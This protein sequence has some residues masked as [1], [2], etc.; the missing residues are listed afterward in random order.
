M[1][2]QGRSAPQGVHAV[3]INLDR[4]QPRLAAVSTEFA[5]CGM[6]F[7]RFAGVNGLAVPE[8]ARPYFFGADGRP[9]QTLTRGEVGCYA[10]HLIL[11]RRVAQGRCEAPT[12]ICEDDIGLPGDFVDILH[13]ALA[14]ADEGWDIIRLSA[15]S[16]RVMWRVCPMPEGYD[17]VRYSKVPVLLGA[18]LISQQGARK[19]LKPGLRTRPVDIDLARPWELDLNIYG[20]APAPVYQ[21]TTNSSSIDALEKRRYPR[22][23]HGFL[24]IRSRLLGR[25]RLAR[26]WHNAR[27]VGLFRTVGAEIRNLLR[28]APLVNSGPLAVHGSK[29]ASARNEVLRV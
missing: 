7:E 9:P 2:V 25:D 27:T 10:S 8:V 20:V 23:A 26:Y 28:D 24:G 5:R 18:Y 4:D 1:R 16:R 14:S 22:R 11:W 12:L 13:A 6:A 17:L 21:P 3:V 15:P 19:L 29:P